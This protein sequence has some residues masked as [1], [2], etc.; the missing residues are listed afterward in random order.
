MKFLTPV[1]F[2]FAAALPVIVFFYLLKLRRVRRVVSSTLLWRRAAEDLHANAPFQKL[3]RNLLLLLQLF[4]AA[5]LVLGLARPA[6]NLKAACTRN[7]VIM[8]DHS[9]SMNALDEANGRSRLDMAKEKARR[10]VREMAPGEAAMVIAFAGKASVLTQFTSDKAR[11]DA[12]LRS[13]AATDLPTAASDAFSLAQSLARPSEARIAVYSD[14]AFAAAGVNLSPRTPCSFIAAGKASRNAGIVTF[15]LRRPPESSKE[16]QIFASIRNYTSAPMEARLEVYNRGKLADAKQLSLPAGAEA[17]QLFSNTQLAEGEVELR[18]I[19][20][21]DLASDN[22]A[23]A[24]IKPPRKRKI[25]LVSAGNYF[26]ERVLREDAV[27]HFELLKMPA[28]QYAPGQQ[29][30]IIIFDNTAPQGPL[31]AGNYF[32]INAMPPVPGFADAGA[33]DSPIIFDWDAQHPAMRYAEL[34]DIQIARARKFTLPQASHVLAESKDTPLISVYSA[35]NRDI[36]LW[37]FDLF[38]SNFPLRIAFP[39]LVS[40]TIDWL[41]RDTPANESSILNTG[42]VIQMDGPKDLR[43]ANMTDPDGQVWSLHP[44]ASNRLLYDRTS[45]VGFYR[46]EINSSPNEVFG[47]SLA[48]AAESDIAPKRSLSFQNAEI[49]AT[50]GTERAIHETW[51]WFALAAVAFLLLEWLIYHKRI[52]V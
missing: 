19:V 16:Y 24:V 11:L 22:F 28:A 36:V 52:W 2:A 3:R 5:L 9:A 25:L 21:D 7:T 4:V 10:A 15:D 50:Y 8:L 31:P 39:I 41:L 27:R 38:E 35:E 51:K 30:D 32:F 44:N 34:G 1:G 13:V 23:Y 18:L 47:V 46:S 20:D 6:M 17:P 45:R 14:G 29:A 26:L 37:S 49:R 40:N 33:E 48:D 43:R 12:A 42:G